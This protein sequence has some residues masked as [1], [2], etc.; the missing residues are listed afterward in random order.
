MEIVMHPFLPS[1][2]TTDKCRQDLLAWKCASN[3]LFCGLVWALAE[4]KALR[5]SR[6]ARACTYACA[7]LP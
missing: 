3:S 1:P 6:A 5:I 4:Q 7:F 2:F